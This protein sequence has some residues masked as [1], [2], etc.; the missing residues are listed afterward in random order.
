HLDEDCNSINSGLRS[1]IIQ[2]GEIAPPPANDECDNAI[3][4]ACGDSVTGSTTSATNSGGNAAGDVF[5]SYTGNGTA[6]E[7]TVSLCGSSYD[8]YL[9]VFTDCT[10]S[11]EIAFNDDDCG[12]QSE[13]TFTSDGTSTYYIMVEGYS[14]NTGNFVLNIS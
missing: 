10:L 6:E 2:C 14:S 12:V 1:R 7:V 11:N 8:T 9:R 13:L 3:A 5:Y 4:V